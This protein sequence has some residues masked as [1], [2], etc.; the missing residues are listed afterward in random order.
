[1][2]RYTIHGPLYHCI[3]LYTK[4]IVWEWT[5]ESIWQGV[6]WNGK[7]AVGNVIIMM[8]LLSLQMKYMTKTMSIWASSPQIP[9]LR[10][11]DIFIAIQ[12]TDEMQLRE[13]WHKEMLYSETTEAVGSRLK[14]H[15]PKGPRFVARW[16]FDIDFTSQHTYA[17][18]NPSCRSYPYPRRTLD[19]SKSTQVLFSKLFSR[20]QSHAQP[21]L[22]PTHDT[23]YKTGCQYKRRL[24]CAMV[25]SSQ[26]SISPPRAT[27]SEPRD[28][29]VGQWH[30]NVVCISHTYFQ[31]T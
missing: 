9:F 26:L 15:A 29:D 24:V 12:G 20:P 8:C 6:S 27:L 17:P 23:R 19:P 1:M 3:S 18:F 25:L 30:L 16:D 31:N 22:S 21:F 10:Y 13:V 11:L 28:I 2:D 14:P 4:R 7:V 5:I